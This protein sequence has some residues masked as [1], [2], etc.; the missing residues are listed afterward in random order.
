MN[1]KDHLERNSFYKIILNKND[2]VSCMTLIFSLSSLHLSMLVFGLQYLE[3]LL[4]NC[5][6]VV[7]GHTLLHQSLRNLCNE[8]KTI[9][10]NYVNLLL[11]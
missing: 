1:I 5:S 7:R 10:F 11:K 3:I 8:L 4:D 6:Y 2:L 9:N